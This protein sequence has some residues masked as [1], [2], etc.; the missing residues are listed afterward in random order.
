MTPPEKS[1]SARPDLPAAPAA[2]SVRRLP[3]NAVEATNKVLTRGNRVRQGWKAPRARGGF[4]YY[5]T[6][7][8]PG[9]LNYQQIV[10]V[11]HPNWIE[12]DAE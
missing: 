10:R 12:A 9:A 7:H 4:L 3:A 1:S 8:Y 11:D 5:E 2:H 6:F